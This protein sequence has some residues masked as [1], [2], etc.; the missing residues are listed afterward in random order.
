MDTRALPRRVIRSR[1]FGLG[2]GAIVLLAWAA[3]LRDH[4][5]TLRQYSWQIA[6]GALVLGLVCGAIYFGGLGLCWALLLRH[7]A[8][9]ERAPSLWTSAR[10]WLYSMSTRY[11]PGNVWHILSRVAF[12]EQLKIPAAQ[13][14]SSAT[15]EQVLTLLGALA[16]FGLTLPFWVV[17]PL[18]QA[19]LLLL[20][21]LGLILIHPAVLGR[22]LAWA[23]HRAKRPELAWHYSY[24]DML[25]LLVAYSSAMLCAGLALYA[26][27]WGLTPIRA[28]ELPFVLG[29]AALAWAIGFLSIFTPSGLGVREAILTALLASVYP[30]PVAI[31]GSLLFRLVLTCG[32]FLAVALAWIYQRVEVVRG[33]ERSGAE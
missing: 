6:P 25:G 24:R 18:A 16:I 30:L 5:T 31:V 8:G 10:V 13:V 4:L 20:V 1:W 17:V 22:I 12:A 11:L 14:L 21:P 26:V 15:I 23:A 7:I 3:F 28:A 33:I 32:E 9:S 29:A 2:V 19:P 27:L